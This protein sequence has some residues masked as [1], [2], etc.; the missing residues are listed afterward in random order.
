MMHTSVTSVC[1]SQGCA[2]PLCLSFPVLKMG[3]VQS[4][5]V[6]GKGKISRCPGA[7]MWRDGIENGELCGFE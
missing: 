7:N 5:P 4:S 2:A 1:T 3:G 6:S